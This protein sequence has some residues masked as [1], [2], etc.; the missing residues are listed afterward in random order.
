MPTKTVGRVGI[1]WRSSS[2]PLRGKSETRLWKL[3]FN[4]SHLASLFSEFSPPC[5]F[6]LLPTLASRV[7]FTF[8]QKSNYRDRYCRRGVGG[9]IAISC[10]RSQWR[11][12]DWRFLISCVVKHQREM[13]VCWLA[14]VQMCGCIENEATQKK[15][16]NRSQKPDFQRTFILLLS[17]M[18]SFPKWSECLPSSWM[19]EKKCTFQRELIKIFRSSPAI[20]SFGQ[21]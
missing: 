6:E 12:D 14:L 8:H 18:R 13:S 5:S 21:K 15:P 11:H 1:Q 19:K 2:S 10:F 17:H 4:T 9:C 20:I 7:L 3:T 16:L